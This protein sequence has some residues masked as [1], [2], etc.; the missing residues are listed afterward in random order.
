MREKVSVR[1]V[2]A[3]AIL[4]MVAVLAVVIFRNYRGDTPE[5]ILGALPKN[6]DLSLKKIDYTETRNGVR[7]W[8]L[9]AD[10][11]NYSVKNTTTHVE[12]IHMTFY[13]KQGRD[14]AT[15]TAQ[16]GEM[17][18]EKRDVSASGDVV[19]STVNGYDFFSDSLFFSENDRKIRTEDPVHIVSSQMKVSGEGLEFDVDSHKYLLRSKVRALI[20]KSDGR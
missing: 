11:A 14:E 19:V 6:V 9:I 1:N 17:H 12:N 16:K 10:S 2:L 3:F 5:A 20:T 8:Q 7:R 15:L 18:T 4:A 13:D